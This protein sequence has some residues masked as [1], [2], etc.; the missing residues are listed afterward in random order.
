MNFL[1]KVKPEILLLEFAF[2]ND[3]DLYELLKTKFMMS[4]NINIYG[5]NDT[6]II[7]LFTLLGIIFLDIYSAPNMDLCLID[8]YKYSKINM[9]PN[10]TLEYLIKEF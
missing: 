3:K 10:G 8:F 7:T 4:K 1:S 2:N 9:L 5:F 6:Y